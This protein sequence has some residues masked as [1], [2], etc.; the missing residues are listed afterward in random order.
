MMMKT[1]SG[2]GDTTNHAL[3]VNSREIGLDLQNIAE[4]GSLLDPLP[5]EL[6]SLVI[7]YGYFNEERT[8]NTVFRTTMML[9]C[10]RLQDIA[11]ETPSVWSIIQLKDLNDIQKLPRLVAHLER[12]KEF[13]LSIYLHTFN[14]DSET[15]DEVMHHLVPH[16]RRWRRLSFCLADEHILSHIRT[17]PLPI[18]E[19]LDISHY[20][21]IGKRLW[22]P[23]FDVHPQHLMHLCLHNIKA[24]VSFQ[25]L[26]FLELQGHQT[27]SEFEK[28][29]K[30]LMDAPLLER[31][32]LHVPRQGV[33]H[34]ADPHHF[35]AKKPPFKVFMPQLRY[36]ELYTSERMLESSVTVMLAFS[37]PKLHRLT[38]REAFDSIPRESR[39]I[40][41]YTNDPRP[42]CSPA[43]FYLPT[44]ET[45]CNDLYKRLFIREHPSQ[46]GFTLDAALGAL[47]TETAE[48]IE[49]LEVD[50]TPCSH[51]DEYYIRKFLPAILLSSLTSISFKAV[52]SRRWKYIAEYFTSHSNDYPELTSLEVVGTTELF[53][54]DPSHPNYADLSKGFPHLRRLALDSA[55]SNTFVRQLFAST[56]LPEPDS[57]PRLE[58]LPELE[59]LSTRNDANVSKPLLSRMIVSRE[60]AGKPL[61]RLFLDRYFL[62]NIELWDYLKGLVDL[63]EI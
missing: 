11:L 31:L 15:I 61:T 36:L 43:P 21:D 2:D 6:L 18:L 35:S 30:L 24:N 3:P 1:P 47:P 49:V 51:L 5:S 38:L 63:S 20:K 45:L 59:V 19:S 53:P 55:S 13:P 12:S 8:P 16:S 27:S 58:A 37:L 14:W 48:G 57:L 23:I 42:P 46:R 60:K 25:G 41:S 7:E 34:S 4:P 10:H 50:Y 32:I 54:M 28:V 9:T 56:L 40:I 22:N 44:E 17:S 52:S 62:V 29:V 26:K 33:D 39:I